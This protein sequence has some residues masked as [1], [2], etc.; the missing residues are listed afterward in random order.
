M[1]PQSSKSNR[2]AVR[3]EFWRSRKAFD[4]ELGRLAEKLEKAWPTSSTALHLVLQHIN[5]Y[6]LYSTV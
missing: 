1:L 2:E 5:G 3:L 6:S 4:S